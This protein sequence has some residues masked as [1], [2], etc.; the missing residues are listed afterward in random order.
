MIIKK[1][2]RPELKDIEV[3]IRYQKMSEGVDKIEKLL[4]TLNHTIPCIEETQAQIQVSINEIFYIESIDKHT[5]VYCR[6]KV[7][8]SRQRLYQLMEEL[9]TDGFVRVSKSCIVNVNC[10]RKIRPLQNSRI[11]AELSNQERI[12]VN[13]KYISD[14]RK[15]LEEKVI[16]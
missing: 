9:M 5:F 3:V 10:I 13:R 16:R 11:E 12:L 8:S 7:Y 14:I 2:Q 1:E 4:L 6:Q 15:Y